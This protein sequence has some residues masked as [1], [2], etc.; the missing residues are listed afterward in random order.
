MEKPTQEKPHKTSTRNLAAHARESA[1]DASSRATTSEAVGVDGRWVA[2]R[3]LMLLSAARMAN[4][5]ARRG[6]TRTCA[7]IDLKEGL[8]KREHLG[9][10]HQPPRLF[11]GCWK[12]FGD[13]NKSRVGCVAK[14]GALHVGHLHP[15][16][17]PRG[18]FCPTCVAKNPG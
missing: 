3:A 16:I 10:L 12:T 1:D 8:S 2:G 6:A 15:K 13:F 7:N 17:A 4:A 11:F 5:T 18:P 9:R 14:G